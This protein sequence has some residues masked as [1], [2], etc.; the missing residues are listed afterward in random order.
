MTVLLNNTILSNFSVVGRPDLVRAA[1]ATEQAATVAAVITE[2]NNGVAQGHFPK[3]DWSWLSVLPLTPDEQKELE[4][5]PRHLGKGEAACL[6]VAR[7]RGWRFATDDWDAR[8]TAQRLGIPITGTI[9]V[10]VILVKDRKLTPEQADGFLTQMI[11]AGFHTPI[12]SVRNV[13]EG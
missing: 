3:C 12:T 11:A 4:Q 9:G 8:R 5:F 10:L 2:H 7:A 1:F 6:A 13:L